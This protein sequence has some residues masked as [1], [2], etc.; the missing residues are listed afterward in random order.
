MNN[1]L[2]C[3]CIRAPHTNTLG[4]HTNDLRPHTKLEC[5]TRKTIL[6]D[7]QNGNLGISDHRFLLHFQSQAKPNRKK[8]QESWVNSKKSSV[9]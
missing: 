7:L 5:G 9:N 8:S 3:Q 6:I 1:G 4:S 2:R